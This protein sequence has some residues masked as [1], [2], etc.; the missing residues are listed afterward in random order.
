M[1]ESSLI[2]GFIS[3]GIYFWLYEHLN[4]TQVTYVAIFPPIVA[5]VI[6]FLF[7]NED[8]SELEYFGTFLILSSGS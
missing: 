4:V 7:L 6:G 3:W 8:L 5:I 2:D 1:S